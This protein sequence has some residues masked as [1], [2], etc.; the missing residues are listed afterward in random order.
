MPD[1][2]MCWGR[3]VDDEPRI[4]PRRDTCYR[5][6]AKPTPGRQSW[7]MVAPFRPE[8]GECEYYWDTDSP[9]LIRKDTE[10]K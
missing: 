6:T 1:I 5:F 7:F 8:T 3:T 2:S 9:S 10:E 4:C